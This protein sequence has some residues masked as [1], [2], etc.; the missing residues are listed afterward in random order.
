[1]EKKHKKYKKP[2]K[3]PGIPDKWFQYVIGLLNANTKISKDNLVLTS[4]KIKLNHQFFLLGDMF[5]NASKIFTKTL[6]HLKSLI[7]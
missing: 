7:F 3:Y 2:K 1:M 6:P 4:L 5:A